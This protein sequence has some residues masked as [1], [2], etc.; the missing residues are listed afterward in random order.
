MAVLE[1]LAAESGKPS[2]AQ[3]MAEAATQSDA[4]IRPLDA[5]LVMM[6]HC[7]E[8]DDDSDD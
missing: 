2:Y 3:L 4:D 8:K 7:L 1:V 5:A 6:P